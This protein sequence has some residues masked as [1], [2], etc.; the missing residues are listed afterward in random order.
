MSLRMIWAY[1]E[2]SIGIIGMGWL[3]YFFFVENGDKVEQNG[4]PLEIGYIVFLFILIVYRYMRAF[5][6]AKR[7]DNAQRR[8]KQ[9]EQ[10]L[11]D[12]YS[13]N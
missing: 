12:K 4:T 13:D 8:I 11:R 3:G 10:E 7:I 5:R 9:R 6:N 1:I 2:L